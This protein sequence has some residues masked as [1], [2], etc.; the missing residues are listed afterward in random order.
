MTPAPKLTSNE[1]RALAEFAKPKVDWS[2]VHGNTRDSLQ[3]K[4][5]LHGHTLT[6]AGR[7]AL[8]VPNIFDDLFDQKEPMPK[9]S[10]AVDHDAFREIVRV[11]V[12]L[13]D[14]VH[15]RFD[16][17]TAGVRLYRTASPLTHGE[18]NA[19]WSLQVRAHVK[20]KTGGTGKQ[21]AIGTASVSR[22][23]LVWLRDQINA[24]LRRKS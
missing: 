11:E 3:R 9:K 18:E 16:D 20:K 24:E 22:E 8:V 13:H 2:K 23:D 6:D 4:K 14:P 10:S 19:R 12:T 1:R 21:F 17:T 7:A 15:E 5:M